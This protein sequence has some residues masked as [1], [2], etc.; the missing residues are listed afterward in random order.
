M[1]HLTPQAFASA[2]SDAGIHRAFLV[3]DAASG[4]VRAS[5]PLLDP[6]A[7][8]FAEDRRDFDHHEGIFLQVAPD[9]GVLQAAFVHRT[10]RGQGSGGLRFWRY[11]TM[12]EFLRDGLRL[13]RGM[14]HKNAL[15]GI[16][17]GGGKG[18]I[19]R[20]TG[21]A[22]DAQARRRIFE[23]YGA[24]LSSLRG[25]YVSAEDAGTVPEDI[26]AVFSASRFVTCI[27][28]ALGGSGNPSA[29]TARGVVRG[30]EAA[31]THLGMGT[32][33]G[34][35][36]AVQGLGHVGEALV[37]FLAERGVARIIGSDVSADRVTGL[38]EKT[39]RF[40]D[41]DLDLRVIERGDDS[42]LAAEADL[43]A[44][45][46]T[47][48]TL[49]PRTI[50][51]I[52]A[53]IVCGAANNQ[54]EDPERDGLALA[55]RGILYLPDFLVNRMGIVNCADESFGS[56]PDDPRIEAHLG[57]EWDNSI[58]NLSLE[59]LARAKDS[60]QTPARV[61]LDLA[62]QRS[63]ELHPIWGHRGA[64]IVASLVAGGWAE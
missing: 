7:Q 44:P 64:Q 15:A 4:T 43:L 6:L 10:C 8:L 23:E 34:K 35:S 2:L 33:E 60:G 45:C 11:D 26:A 40:P 21:R 30:M 19:A 47:G 42:I 48:G 28:P 39:S 51:L 31:L 41:L 54:L 17:W 61:A 27:P 56:L 38:V 49:N 62:E 36:V 24:F 16:W 5:H 9:T 46:A 1:R 58:Y 59:I 53:R 50:S 52:R 12:E 29:P 32:L 63:F 55:E 3:W 37:G 57:H 14:T 13:S 20:D 22:E 18:V 25:C